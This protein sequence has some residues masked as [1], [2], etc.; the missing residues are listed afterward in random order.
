MIFSSLIYSNLSGHF[1]PLPQ[2]LPSSLSILP[3]VRTTPQ[4]HTTTPQCH[5]PL[6]SSLQ[7]SRLSEILPNATQPL[8][9]ATNH[10]LLAFK[11]TDCQNSSQMPHHHCYATNCTITTHNYIRVS[12]FEYCMF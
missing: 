6:P 5:K 10:S 11:S 1:S 9:Y 8:L 7:F 3:T 2:P 4:C 12:N